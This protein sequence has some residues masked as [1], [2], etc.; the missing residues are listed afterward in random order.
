MSICPSCPRDPS[1]VISRT[2]LSRSQEQ[3]YDGPLYDLGSDPDEKQVIE[4]ET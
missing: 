1:G 3:A 2:R 4:I